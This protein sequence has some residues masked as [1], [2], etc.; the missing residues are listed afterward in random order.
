MKTRKLGKNGPELT[1]IGF[2]AWAIGGPWIYGWGK[3]DDQES[4]KAIHRTLDLGVNWVDTAAAYGFGHS[5]I[6]VGKALKGIRQNVFV[7]T[8]CG[9]VPDGKGDAVRNSRP[10]SIMKEIDAS[11]QRLQTDHVDLYQI[12]WP[13]DSVPIEDSWETMVRIRDEGKA[14]YIGVS[15]YDVAMMKRCSSL[16]PPLSLQPP[17]SMLT[18][19]AEREIFP[20][21]VKQ[22]IGAI[23]YS[24][25]QSGLLTGRFDLSRVA[26]DDWRRKY[27]WFQEPNLSKALALVEELRPIARTRGQT[28]GQLAVQW[29]LHSPAVTAAI[30][31]A[32][33]A[34]QV[35]E[36]VRA[37]EKEL[38]DEEYLEVT[39]IVERHFPFLQD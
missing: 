20:F 15:N 11:L 17:Y 24:P 35:E 22:G 10:E 4:I 37:G 25:M 5:E 23:V 34:T 28:V 19:D 32:R 29:V 1:V 3:V 31:G 18:R 26:Q 13:D 2:G 36:N 9:L 33:S 39:K 6:V 7:A 38:S 30:V 14:R 8:K 27:F 16:A 12:H 21:C